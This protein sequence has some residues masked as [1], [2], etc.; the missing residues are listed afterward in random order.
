MVK[1]W[2]RLVVCPNC[3]SEQTI[4]EETAEMGGIM[5]CP[6]CGEDYEIDEALA[7]AESEAEGTDPYDPTEEF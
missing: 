5:E 1:P 6:V 4:D 3:G 2:E 7:E